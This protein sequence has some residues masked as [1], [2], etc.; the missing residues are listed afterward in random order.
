MQLLIREIE[1]VVRHHQNAGGKKAGR[2]SGS[3]VDT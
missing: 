3:N 2:T 1:A